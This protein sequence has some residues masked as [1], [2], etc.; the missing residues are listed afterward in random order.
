MDK[1]NYDYLRAADDLADKF[2]H[3]QQQTNWAFL[4]AFAA[5]MARSMRWVRDGFA[6]EMLRTRKDDE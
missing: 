1:T 3:M 2:D 4:R 5:F 6:D